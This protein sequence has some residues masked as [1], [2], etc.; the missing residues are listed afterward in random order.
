MEWREYYGKIE[1]ERES[2]GSFLPK[3]IDLRCARACRVKWHCV[4]YCAS[5]YCTMKRGNV[6]SIS[7]SL[8]IIRSNVIDP[9]EYNGCIICL[10]R[11]CVALSCIWIMKYVRQYIIIF[12][13]IQSVF[14]INV[15]SFEDSLF[16]MLFNESFIK[17]KR[18][19]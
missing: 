1:L 3:Y 8:Y 19:I 18:K 16:T 13:Y 10:I 2:R 12:S 5:I 11:N 4:G 15:Q 17:I 6:S 9:G 7:A 14:S